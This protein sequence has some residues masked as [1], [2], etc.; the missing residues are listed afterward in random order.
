MNIRIQFGVSPF[1]EIVFLTKQN[2]RI[3]I[4]KVT[5]FASIIIVGFDLTIAEVMTL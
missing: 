4:L 3:V 2:T 5:R 1:D